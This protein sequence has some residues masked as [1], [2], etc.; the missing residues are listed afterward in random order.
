MSGEQAGSVLAAAGL[1][2][3][4]TMREPRIRAAGFLAWAIGVLVVAGDL[5]SSPVATLRVEA[6]RRPALA[7]AGI[8][9]AL[10]GLA[11]AA[12]LLDRWPWLLLIAAVAA[13]PARVP[14]H[15]GGQ[16]A[17]LLVP[18][19]GVIA[20]AAVVT[21]WRML[22][23]A[24][25]PVLLGKVGWAAAGLI[26][27]S[28]VSMLWTVD[29]HQGSVEMLFF[30]LPFGFLLARLG[31]LAPG[32]RDLKLALGVQVALAL[33]FA[34]VAFFQEATHHLF[35]N[36]KVIVGND[37]AAFFRVNS[38][39][40]DASIYGRFM[41]LTLVL[42][43]GVCVYK[44]MVWPVLAVMAVL[45]AALYFA[46]SQSSLLALAAG[47]LLLGTGFW[48]RRVTIGLG[49]GA[50][51]VGLAAL[52]VA[53]HGNSTKNVSS[54]RSTLI[55][56]GVRVVRHHPLDGAGIGGFAR[57]AVAGTKHPNRVAGAASHTTPMTVVAEIG[58][59]GLLLYIALLVS[60]A[61]AALHGPGPPA[62]R[63]TLAAAFGALFVASLFYN[64]FFEDP[65]SWILMALIATLPAQT[66]PL[67]E[68]PT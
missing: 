27:F 67:R 29:P 63:L 2:P 13:A 66:V 39:F 32:T 59:L 54:D 42:L 45:F 48:S 61:A 12:W 52:A 33:V 22:R 24:S 57:A 47:T 7:V 41:A 14:F 68:A 31:G 62:V 46:Y 17:N 18:L 5:L 28:G 6:T 40:W 1:V 56:D 58:P 16:E 65:A 15:A 55:S 35:W 34:V 51:V 37:Y 20:V 10:V 64:A 23:G 38:L 4:L 11:V 43:A 36:P 26:L 8:L 50:I 44:R 30:Y 53:L 25:D 21:G 9:L 49:V 19:Y 60:V 3:L